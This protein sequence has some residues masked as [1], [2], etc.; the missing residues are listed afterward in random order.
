MRKSLTFIIAAIIAFIVSSCKKD[1]LTIDPNT[2]DNV[3]TK[4]WYVTVTQLVSGNQV[5]NS[6]Y[7]WRNERALVLSLQKNKDVPGYSATY[8]ENTKYAG[9]FDCER[10]NEKEK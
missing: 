2:L 3:T 8:K 7:E 4:C 9:Q 1:P 10:A 5:S 6:W